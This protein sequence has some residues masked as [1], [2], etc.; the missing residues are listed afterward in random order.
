MSARFATC[1]ACQARHSERKGTFKRGLMY[2]QTLFGLEHLCKRLARFNT[3]CV[4][5]ELDLLNLVVRLQVLNVWLNVLGCGELEALALEGKYFGSRHCAQRCSQRNVRTCKKEVAAEG[6]RRLS[7]RRNVLALVGFICTRSVGSRSSLQP[8][9]KGKAGT[10][11]S[12]AP[13][14]CQAWSD[15]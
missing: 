2:L 11:A 8:S 1:Q 6:C 14:E 3:K 12:G 13:R 15:R 7:C 5:Q 4:A 10:R 9:G